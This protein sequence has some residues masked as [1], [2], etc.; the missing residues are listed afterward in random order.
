[1]ADFYTTDN[2]GYRDRHPNH[3]R[4]SEIMKNDIPYFLWSIADALSKGESVSQEQIDELF[5]LSQQM[6]EK[7]LISGTDKVKIW[8][9]WEMSEDEEYRNLLAVFSSK[10]KAEAAKEAISSSDI[11]HLFKY[12]IDVYELDDL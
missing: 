1:M 7:E 3:T 4:T 5:L 8:T 6:E 9:L 11:G 12:E 10:E 2:C